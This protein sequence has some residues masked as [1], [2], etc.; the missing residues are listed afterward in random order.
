ML[1]VNLLVYFQC[2]I[3]L[4]VIVCGYINFKWNANPPFSYNSLYISSVKLYSCFISSVISSLSNTTI[5]S[6]NQDSSSFLNPFF[7]ISS[8]AL[9]IKS[10]LSSNLFSVLNLLS[11]S[12]NFSLSYFIF[13]SN[14]CFLSL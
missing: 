13:F 7:F 14:S 10:S 1:N 2:H 12:C 9:N 4:L 3:L 8:I 11:A 6:N 5:L